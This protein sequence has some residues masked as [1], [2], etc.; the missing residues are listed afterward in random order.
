MSLLTSFVAFF[1]VGFRPGSITTL[2]TLATIGTVWL[3]ARPR[4]IWPKRFL[5]AVV[6]GYWIIATPLGAG[7]L[8]AGL[9]RGYKPVTVDEARGATAVVVLSGGANTYTL[10]GH[11]SGL[12]SMP[13]MLRAL[14]GA[15]AYRLLGNPW[16]IASGGIPLHSH[17][18]MPEADMLRDALIE[19]GV[20]SSRILIE[21]SSKDTHDQAVLVKSMLDRLG[22]HRFVLVTS[23]THMR[24]AMASFL[25]VGL[26]P[27]AS[28]TSMRSED[29]P[30]PPLF[31]PS[32][33]ALLESDAAI[34]DYA[35]LGYY[36]LRRW[37]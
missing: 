33:E 17:Q 15:R 35:A 23:P 18:K 14:E 25:A 10:G 31:V 9:S 34:Y 24:R 2:W 19:A 20:D 28:P 30:A 11:T 22:V 27:I 21:S 1:K 8:V 6:A 12:L 36:W 3:V 26:D 16:M 7:V 13:S 5:V 37:G 32:P 4:S 29:L